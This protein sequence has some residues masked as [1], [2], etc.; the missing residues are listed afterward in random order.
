MHCYDNNIYIYFFFW[1]GGGW[2]AG[3]LLL[4]KYPTKNPG[5]TETRRHQTVPTNLRNLTFVNVPA[6]SHPFFT[7]HTNV[8]S[9][10]SSEI[11]SPFYFVP[12][13]AFTLFLIIIWTILFDCKAFAMQP[14]F[15]CRSRMCK[16]SNERP[17]AMVKME[18]ETA[19]RE[20][21]WLFC[22]LP[23]NSRQ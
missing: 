7:S 19:N 21:K 6:F 15:V 1:G 2:G 14:V 5:K 3:K 13:P 4:L 17:E 12:L 11:T 9:A 18:R 16:R 22:S 23:S 10:M 8:I 20:K